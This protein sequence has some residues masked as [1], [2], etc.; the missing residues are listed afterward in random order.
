[1]Y[2]PNYPEDSVLSRHFEATV[3]LKRQILL[4]TPPS[5]SV[6]R[7][8]AMSPSSHPT[9][10]SVTGKNRAHVP[11]ASAASRQAPE[12]KGFMAWLFGLFGR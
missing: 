8:H 1:M 6:L 7:R 9:T 12:E 5:D 10:R 4:Q 3:E 2:I 11:P